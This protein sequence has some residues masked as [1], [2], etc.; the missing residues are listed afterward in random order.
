M[1]RP[2]AEK[3]IVIAFPA[4]Q[5]AHAALESLRYLQATREM[6]LHRAAVIV[7]SNRGALDISE[8]ND[9][10]PTKKG[11]LIS[12]TGCGGFVIGLLWRGLLCGA[13]VGCLAGQTA[14]IVASVIDLGYGDMYLKELAA[15]VPSGRSELVTTVSPQPSRILDLLLR[16]FPSAT[17]VAVAAVDREG[18]PVSSHRSQPAMETPTETR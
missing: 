7:R 18:L 10:S 16:Q 6:K 8:T 4:T 5:D 14:A 9:V 2:P 3:T 15:D 13:I 17:V 1:R 11:L 12:L